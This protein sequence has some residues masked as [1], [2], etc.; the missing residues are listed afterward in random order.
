ME[1]QQGQWN[2][3]NRIEKKYLEEMKG[4]LKTYYT[5]LG[6]TDIKFKNCIGED[7]DYKN[8]VDIQLKLNNKIINVSLRCREQLKW[9]DVTIRNSASDSGCISEWGKIQN[10]DCKADILLFCW[11][12]KVKV[13]KFAII[14]MTSIEFEIFNKI[15]KPLKHNKFPDGT[16]DGST[17]YPIGLY[18]LDNQWYVIKHNLDEQTLKESSKYWG[19]E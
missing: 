8:C 6:Y 14:D 17:F 10:G 16:P 3:N 11:C 7:L 2:V 19:W 13:E 9:F 18:D 12:D 1:K 5:E 4:M 15:K